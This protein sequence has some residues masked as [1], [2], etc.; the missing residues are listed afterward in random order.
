MLHKLSLRKALR[1]V[2]FLLTCL[3]MTGCY[4]LKTV[5]VTSIPADKQ[6][7]LIH[8]D[9]NYW[10]VGNY[11][12]SDGILTA[13]LVSDAVK[14]SKA[15]TVHIYV[16]PVSSVTV[17]GTSLTVPVVNIGKTDYQAVNW[18]ETLGLS[19]GVGWIL[20]MLIVP[21]FAY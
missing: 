10:T 4:T 20:Y 14:A 21:L 18:W 1:T 11:S 8:A 13:Q 17:E 3:L 2:M 19:A 15:K 7:M 12:V 16:A 5:S 6:V 9:E